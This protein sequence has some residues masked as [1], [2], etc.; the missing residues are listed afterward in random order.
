[1]K[2]HSKRYRTDAG[3]IDANKRY[4]VEEAVKVLKSTTPTKFD[5]SVEVAIKLNIDP[6]KSEQGVRGSLAL[7]KGIGKSRKV[8]VF[9][10]GADAD[11]AK[12]SGADEIGM[13][14]LAKKIEDGWLDFDVALALPRTMKVIAKLG[15][16]LGPQGKM[17]SPKSGTVTE[18]IRTAVREFKAGKIEFRNDK[19]GNVQAAVGKLSFS[20]ADL[21][22]NV[23]AFVEHIRGMRPS[24]VKGHYIENVALSASMSPPVS[25][26]FQTT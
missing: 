19:D 10:D 17:P 20:E 5:Q 6:T 25:L 11:A 26:A 13:A 4:S 8:I 14:E 2:K 16:I 18:D 15:K 22:A 12:E 21:R 1:M 24:T 7:P 3:K 23:E 9:A